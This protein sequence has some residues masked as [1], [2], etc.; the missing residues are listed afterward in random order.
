MIRE[1]LHGILLH[2][3]IR[4]AL[5]YTGYNGWSRLAVALF[6]STSICPIAKSD[7]VS[8]DTCASFDGSV[9]D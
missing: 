4:D 5:R 3:S 8:H 1:P 9:D 6:N 2:M 7:Y